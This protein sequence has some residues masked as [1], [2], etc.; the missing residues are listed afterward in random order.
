MFK[1]ALMGLAVL[2]KQL[3]MLRDKT[4]FSIVI[5]A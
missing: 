1:K 4:S 3:T 5:L 2:I